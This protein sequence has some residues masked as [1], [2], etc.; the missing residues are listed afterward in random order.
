MSV[1]GFCAK[2]VYPLTGD[3]TLVSCFCLVCSLSGSAKH[4]SAMFGLGEKG[5]TA[6]CVNKL[7]GSDFSYAERKII[8]WYDYY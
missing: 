6:F 5:Q 3:G 7:I 8:T 4:T 1:P 2:P